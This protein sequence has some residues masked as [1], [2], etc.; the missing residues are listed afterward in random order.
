M[1]DETAHDTIHTSLE[2]PSLSF[3]V[4]SLEDGIYNIEEL[5]DAEVLDY[6]SFYGSLQLKGTLRRAGDR[7]HLEAKA[8][9][10]GRFECTRCADSFERAIT[11]D[12]RVDFVPPYLERDPEDEDVHVY[13]PTVSPFIDITGDVRDALIL[14]IPMKHL[15]RPDCKGL[16]ADCGNNRNTQECECS[17]PSEIGSNWSALKGLQQRLR[18]EESKGEAEE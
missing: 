12:V 8:Q 10:D 7:F 14:S 9:V 17:V 11:A 2:R 6:P 5:R 18:A 4:R 15:C 13:D 16:C 3:R 1:S